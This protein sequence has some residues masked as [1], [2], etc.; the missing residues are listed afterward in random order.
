[1]TSKKNLFIYLGGLSSLFSQPTMR[2]LIGSSASTLWTRSHL[3]HWNV[4]RTEPAGPGSVRPSLML[5]WH[6]GQHGPS[7]GMSD[8]STEWWG[9]N[10]VMLLYQAVMTRAYS[11]RLRVRAHSSTQAYEVRRYP[12][13]AEKIGASFWLACVGTVFLRKEYG[14]GANGFGTFPNWTERIRRM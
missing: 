5:A 9:P 13:H 14:T 4:S 11:N 3:V 6:L 2:D 1:M 10:T 7:I 8:D 12:H